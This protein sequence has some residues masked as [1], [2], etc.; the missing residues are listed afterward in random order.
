MSVE[1]YD[2]FAQTFFDSTVLA[3]MGDARDRFLQHIPLGGA[4]LDA[5][6]GSGRDAR[7]FSRAGFKV[8]AYDASAGMVRL[9]REYSKLPVR[10][11]T[12]E[13]MQWLSEFDGIWACASLLHVPRKDLPDTFRR[14]GLALKAGGRWYLSMK[15][16]VSTRVVDGRS[17]TDVTEAEITGLLNS[18]GLH[19][20]DLWITNDVRSGREDRWVNTIAIKPGS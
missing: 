1:Y 11:L 4:I 16:G 3:D 18:A 12:F 10:Q 9:A 14:F 2:K 15:Y 6:C 19:V 17:F 8:T 20:A 7:A 13:Q 5:G